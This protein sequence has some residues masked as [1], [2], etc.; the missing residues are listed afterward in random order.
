M[1][2]GSLSLNHKPQRRSTANT[3]EEEEEEEEKEEGGG[4][5]RGGGGEEEEEEKKKEEE[6]EEEEEKSDWWCLDY[7]SAKACKLPPRM[8]AVIRPTSC[9]YLKSVCCKPAEDQYSTLVKCVLP[10]VTASHALF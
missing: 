3:E 5:E 9:F 10:T 6:E 4:G 8:V 7:I 2:A 1:N